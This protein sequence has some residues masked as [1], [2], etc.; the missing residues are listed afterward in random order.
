MAQK[1]RESK[2]K[3]EE[4]LEELRKK[5]TTM[6]HQLQKNKM[7]VAGLKE[8]E[9]TLNEQ[10]IRLKKEVE[11]TT[12]DKEK[13]KELE[14]TVEK[15]QKEWNKTNTAASKIENEVQALNKK[16]MDIGGAKMSGQQVN[17]CIIYYVIM[18]S[19]LYESEE[20]CRLVGL[21]NWMFQKTQIVL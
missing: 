19:S 10:I 20:L 7:E 11:K 15:F 21:R 5:I 1:H 9:Q 13:L 2:E 4:N 6:E 3:L 17:T 18:T 12:P 8:Q 16:I 14:T